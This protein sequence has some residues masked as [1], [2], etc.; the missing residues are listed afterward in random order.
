MA[1]MENGNQNGNAQTETTGKTFTQDELNAILGDRLNRE[2]E[3]YADYEDLKAKAQ[4]FDEQE[5]ASKSELQKANEKADELQK[6]LDALQR[7]NTIRET[8]QK[9]AT[10]LGIP[11]SLLNADTEEAC[12]EQAQAILDFAGTKPKYPNVKDGGESH[13]PSLSKSDILSIKD[14]RQRIEAIKQNIELFN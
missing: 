12:R 2:R 6:Q 14:E 8:R 1:D 10:E 4:K 7:D 11:A 13:T 5:E 9:V 3:K